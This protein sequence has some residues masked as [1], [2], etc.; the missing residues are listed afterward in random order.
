MTVG[1]A[2]LLGALRGSGVSR[3]GS[4]SVQ[5]DATDLAGNYGQMAGT[6]KVTR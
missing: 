4:Y 5:L 1:V 6:I 3:P 2:V